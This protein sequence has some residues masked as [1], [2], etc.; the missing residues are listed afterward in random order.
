MN[1][2]K[3]TNYIVG[4][5]GACKKTRSD[6][7]CAQMVACTKRIMVMV[8]VCKQYHNNGRCMKTN[9]QKISGRWLV[10][11]ENHVCRKIHDDKSHMVME[12]HMGL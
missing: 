7:K 4:D 9:T 5:G 2:E 11:R 10:C 8:G 12:G 3:I 1:F 6:G